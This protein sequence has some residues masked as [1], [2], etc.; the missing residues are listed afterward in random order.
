MWW[1]LL[2]AGLVVLFFLSGAVRTIT[3]RVNTH[4]LPIL[5]W[6]YL[7]G[8]PWH[9]K[10]LTDRTWK[11]PGQHAL[12]PTKHAPKFHFKSRRE[13]TFIRVT[14]VLFIVFAAFDLVRRREATIIFLSVW[15]AYFAVFYGIK[16]AVKWRGRKHKR[17]WI[18]TA[19]Y[20]LAKEF[21]WPVEASAD[22]IELPSD[23]SEAKLQLPPGHHWSDPKEQEKLAR[24]AMAKLGL[25]S[26]KPEF[27]LAGPDSFLLLKKPPYIPSPVYLCDV[28]QPVMDS[29]PDE[30][31][32]GLGVNGEPVKISL[33]GD[34]P[35]V[36]ISMAGSP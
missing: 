35:H 30:L 33:H 36:G 3:G 20:S 28:I 14:R 31:V 15:A 12:T 26:A 32:L 24:A 6:R 9:G 17:T 23:R 7:T 13:Q 34:S 29:A 25:P 5:A 1:F 11:Q 8:Q 10:P 18:D 2:A 22:W 16:G 21:K 4:G 19:H 27:H